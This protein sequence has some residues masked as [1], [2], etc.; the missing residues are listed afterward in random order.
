MFVTTLFI[1]VVRDEWKTYQ[2]HLHHKN[3]GKYMNVRIFASIFSN[4]IINN[5]TIDIR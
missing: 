5:K 1:I 2:Y 4:A 3:Q